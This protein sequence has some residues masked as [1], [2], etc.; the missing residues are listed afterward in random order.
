VKTP[1]AQQRDALLAG[2]RELATFSAKLAAFGVTVE[3]I[4]EVF[5]QTAQGEELPLERLV[6]LQQSFN[7]FK[8]FKFETIEQTMDAPCRALAEV[9]EVEV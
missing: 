6:S 1:T 9:M 3:G 5:Q 2:A 7:E 4:M 8:N